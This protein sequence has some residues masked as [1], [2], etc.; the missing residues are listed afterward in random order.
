MKTKDCFKDFTWRDADIDAWLP[1][2]QKD[3]LVGKITSHKLQVPLTF[4]EMAQRFIGTTDIEKIK[5]HTLSLPMIDVLVKKQENGED[6]GLRT[7]GYAN[8]FFVENADGSVSVLGVY[9]YDG[10][11]YARVGRLGCGFGWDAGRCLLLR[12]SDA[13]ALGSSEPALTLISEI[14][15]RLAKLKK[16]I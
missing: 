3:S 2:N 9:R 15:E 12:N 11:W 14:E 16:L 4:L 8:F 5:E 1:K 13:L 6:V 7:D 10:G